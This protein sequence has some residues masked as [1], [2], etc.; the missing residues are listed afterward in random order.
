MRVCLC[1]CVGVP[2]WGLS[3]LR[4]LLLGKFSLDL[5]RLNK[6][7]GILGVKGFI[8]SFIL[9]VA[10]SLLESHL[11]LESWQSYGS[12]SGQSTGWRSLYSNT[13]NNDS[14]KH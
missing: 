4:G 6:N 1:V 12:A 11:P 10:G 5:V 9:T 3:R 8:L 2:S 14:C 7:T 13:D